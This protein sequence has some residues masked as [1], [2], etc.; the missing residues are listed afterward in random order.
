MP[1][2]K[3]LQKSNYAKINDIKIPNIARILSK[4]DIVTPKKYWYAYNLRNVCRMNYH[5][6]NFEILKKYSR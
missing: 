1:M 4:Y 3:I 5:I 2:I 6:E